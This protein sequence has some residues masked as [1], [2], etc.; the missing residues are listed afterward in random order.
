MRVEITIILYLSQP[1]GKDK[2]AFVHFL[3]ESS[4]SLLHAFMV[5][6]IHDFIISIYQ[7]VPGL[8]RNTS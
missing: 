1:V 5:N 7:F 4:Y 8:D 2:Y 6:S 3:K